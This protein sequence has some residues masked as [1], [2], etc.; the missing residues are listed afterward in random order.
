MDS[1]RRVQQ[2]PAVAAT[3]VSG[4]TSVEPTL[5]P[6]LAT[7]NLSKRKRQTLNSST[8]QQPESDSR[9]RQ[10]HVQTTKEA[11]AQSMQAESYEQSTGST[12][13]ESNRQSTTQSQ[14]D[15]GSSATATTTTQ[16]ASKPRPRATDKGSSSS[17]RRKSSQSKNQQ[18]QSSD[19]TIANND[20]NDNESSDDDDDE[21]PDALTL[22]ERERVEVFGLH[23]Q[24][25]KTAEEEKEQEEKDRKYLEELNTRGYEYNQ[26]KER[27]Y[28]EAEE[29]LQ[30]ASK[31]FGYKNENTLNSY[32]YWISK[33]RPY[34][35]RRFGYDTI[36]PA[37]VFE[38]FRDNL[39]GKKNKNG[40]YFGYSSM[41]MCR[42]ALG[43]E[44]KK[45][46]HMADSLE[47]KGELGVMGPFDPRRFSDP[48]EPR[49]LSLLK[50]QQRHEGA[51]RKDHDHDRTE[52]RLDEGYDEEDLIKMNDVAL[53]KKQF[54]VMRDRVMLL[55]CHFFLLRSDNVRTMNL[56]DLTSRT[57]K[58]SDPTEFTLFCGLTNEGKVNKAGRKEMNAV[59]RNKD[60]RIC[61]VSAMAI[62]LAYRFDVWPDGVPPDFSSR[63]SWYNVKLIISTMGIVN[64]QGPRQEKVAQAEV[65]EEELQEVEAEA[66]AQEEGGSWEVK[67]DEEKP[68][69]KNTHHDAFRK[70]YDSADVHARKMTHGRVSGA[71]DLSL[72]G[73][74]DKEIERIGHWNSNSMTKSY[75]GPIPIGAVRLHA[76]FRREQGTYN[77]PRAN[78]EPPIELRRIIFPFVEEA[79]PEVMGR[80][81][82]RLLDIKHRR[83]VGS[84]R[85]D[86]L[87]ANENGELPDDPEDANFEGL[88]EL[89]QE[90]YSNSAAFATSRRINQHGRLM[91]A[92]DEERL[93][94]VSDG[95]AIA[96]MKMLTKM[97]KVL[98]QDMAVLSLEYP[99]H[100][101]LEHPVFCHEKWP[102][103]RDA[104]RENVRANDT[105]P[106]LSVQI[107][108]CMPEM[109]A[110]V[111]RISAE[112]KTMK[113]GVNEVKNDI[114]L[115][116]ET[117]MAQSQ[118]LAVLAQNQQ[119]HSNPAV[120]VDRVLQMECNQ[121]QE[122]IQM[123]HERTQME[124]AWHEERMRTFAGIQYPGGEISASKSNDDQN[125][126]D[127]TRSVDEWTPT[128][129]EQRPT[130]SGQ[131]LQRIYRD[132]ERPVGTAPV[133]QVASWED[134]RGRFQ[135][136]QDDEERPKND[137]SYK[138]MFRFDTDNT[139]LDVKGVWN[140]FMQGNKFMPSVKYM[141][142]HFGRFSKFIPQKQRKTAQRRIV[143]VDAIIC[144]SEIIGKA[145][146]D[147][148][149]DLDKF[150]RKG[151]RTLTKMIG[152]LDKSQI[153]WDS[154][155]IPHILR[156]PMM[157][158]IKGKK[159]LADR[160][161]K[162]W[163]RHK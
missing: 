116:C 49:L 113:D 112:L 114:K 149:T 95:A 139:I 144:A 39:F 140:Q 133:P 77:L 68:I 163:A 28:L 20:E 124:H 100:P 132:H 37:F 83:K 50:A 29:A 7:T 130:P 158:K 87:V 60:P 75:L 42:M 70:L 15:T 79:Y 96:F 161:H 125:G 24:F 99:D 127:G 123:G 35:E 19:P 78:I 4:F 162:S 5:V 152:A 128:P 106:P 58:T 2:R 72:K 138:E 57:L 141:V 153:D 105:N 25:R 62:Y 34:A 21:D 55:L 43:F 119:Q 17:K 48:F 52:G 117:V 97:R 137:E 23:K 10:R 33:W 102:E 93:K 126:R 41:K 65:D 143:L 8:L 115:L 109:S 146:D 151:S 154:K 44:F 118:Q 104:V 148:I 18:K 73:A 9:K 135:R 13:T 142:E 66:V 26:V 69:H 108:T 107:Q 131:A 76:G 85:A 12:T 22:D 110:R 159:E 31:T 71:N 145:P 81:R 122:R 64:R 121:H 103:F 94:G 89:D 6:E 98:L 134:F 45:Q 67:Y 38:F 101:I 47:C 36:T 150:L 84:S 92:A 27:R 3:P 86:G 74:T 82:G 46:L 155:D 120:A 91:N 16:P 1:Y 63:E 59:V 61:L 14:Q 56:C 30:Y 11:S 136:A 40:E 80:T 88:E 156:T 147:I 51:R 111:E 157:A 129:V 32:N 53:R 54:F 160:G 90:E